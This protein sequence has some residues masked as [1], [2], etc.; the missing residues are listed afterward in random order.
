MGEGVCHRDAEAQR[1]LSVLPP[2][3]PR[4]VAVILG[5]IP[6]STITAAVSA[7]TVTAFAIAAGREEFL[8]DDADDHD[9]KD[10]DQGFHRFY[11]VVGFGSVSLLFCFHF[12]FL[13]SAYFVPT[14]AFSQ[15]WAGRL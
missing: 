12:H 5:L 15:V 6:A 11:G 10:D 13:A 9:A 1:V 4:Q 3:V 14:Q 7:A 2:S 8:Q